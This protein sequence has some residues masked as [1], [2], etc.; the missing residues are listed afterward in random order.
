MTFWLLV[1]AALTAF[2]E[3]GHATAGRRMYL[4]PAVAGIEDDE[5]RAT[6]K[7]VWHITDVAFLM[8]VAGTLL[9]V[10]VGS[11][12]LSVPIAGAASAFFASLVVV[13][14]WFALRSGIANAPI[15]LFQWAFFLAAAA[16]YLMAA[17]S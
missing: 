12:A 10:Y 15:K 7:F 9:S 11:S 17:L 5:V 14:L 2:I 4:D 6:I 16:A 1:G 3:V 8:I 13:H